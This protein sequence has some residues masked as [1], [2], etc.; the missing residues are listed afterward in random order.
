MQTVAVLGT[1]VLAM[2]LHPEVQ[3]KGRATID[4]VIGN[5]RLPDISDRGTMPYLDAI[6][7]ESLRWRVFAPIGESFH[8]LS[9]DLLDGICFR[10]RAACCQ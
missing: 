7:Y 5:S 2:L 8:S 3:E 6:M 1:F 4:A 9:S 10:S